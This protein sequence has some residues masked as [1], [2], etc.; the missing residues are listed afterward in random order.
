MKEI[1]EKTEIELKK[2]LSEN[3]GALRSFRFSGSG[4]KTRD[5]KEG[6]NLRKNIARVL[7]EI[8]SR[9]LSDNSSGRER[10]KPIK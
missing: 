4:G 9:L 5:V 6:R 2:M 8:N 10:I 7:T 1:K 3:R